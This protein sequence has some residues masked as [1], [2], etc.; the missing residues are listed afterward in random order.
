MQWTKGKVESR[1]GDWEGGRS[2]NLKQ[3][4]VSLPEQRLEG[5]EGVRMWNECA[6]AFLAS[7]SS[8]D[9]APF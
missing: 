9:M 5:D 8:A 3:N 6:Q 1:E 7:R 2:Y 4:R